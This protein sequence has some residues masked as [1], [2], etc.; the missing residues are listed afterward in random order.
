M[1]RDAAAQKLRD[2]QRKTNW[3]RRHGHIV[4]PNSVLDNIETPEPERNR[5]NPG[6]KK[7]NRPILKPEPKKEDPNGCPVSEEDKKRCPSGR[8]LYRGD[9]RPPMD[10]NKAIRKGIFITGFQGNGT[11]GKEEKLLEDLLQYVLG[12]TKSR[13]VGTSKFIPPAAFFAT[14]YPES[15][16]K[17]Y[18]YSICDPGGGI[19][20]NQELGNNPG[21]MKSEYSWQEEVVFAKGIPARFIIGATSYERRNGRPVPYVKIDEVS[22]QAEPIFE[23]NPN[24]NPEP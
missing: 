16:F 12:N 4:P 5:H 11:K 23:I 24:Y 3:L 13:F 14:K 22:G 20:V 2:R 1:L 17:G 18:V 7:P 9:T 8:I 19:D 21:F 6:N 10:P 15:K